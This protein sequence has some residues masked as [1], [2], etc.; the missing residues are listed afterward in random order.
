M[1][2]QGILNTNGALSVRILQKND[3]QRAQQLRYEI[4]YNELGANNPPANG[5]DADKYDEIC[6]H[7]GV[8][9]GD[10][11]CGVYRLLRRE[12]LQGHKFY[13][14]GEYDI[15]SIYQYNGNICE[16]GRSCV[17]KNYRTKPVMELLWRGIASF[18][19]HYKIDLMFGCASFMGTDP[20]AI[21]GQL[22]YLH[23]YHLAGEQLRPSVLPSARAIQVDFGQFPPLNDREK[24]RYFTK[25]PPLIKG[26][27]RLGGHIGQGAFLDLEFNTIDVFIIVETN[28]V[29]DWYF[30]HFTKH[31]K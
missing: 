28:Q 3:I 13:S 6:D 12:T 10:E 25:L 18:V 27:I 26:Y 1:A 15:T 23:K 7:L 31:I 5:L 24:L 4:F 22:Q 2:L 17:A 8:F 14:A 20:S 30:N 11:L 21:D 16:F 29:N 9:D 19:L